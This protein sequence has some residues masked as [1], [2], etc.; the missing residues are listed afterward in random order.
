MLEQIGDFCRDLKRIY[1]TRHVVM[2]ILS[3]N[4]VKKKLIQIFVNTY[5]L[6]QA[7]NVIIRYN[8][9]LTY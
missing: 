3:K 5:Q 2:S 7:Y 4:N 8:F 6:Y 9:T 1:K